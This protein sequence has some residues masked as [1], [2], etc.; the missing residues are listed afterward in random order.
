MNNPTHPNPTEYD[1]HADACDHDAC[2]DVHCR[3]CGRGI[4]DA[5]GFNA[6]G[7]WIGRCEGCEDNRIEAEGYRAQRAQEGR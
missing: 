3:D 4:T 2:S 5:T 1:E 7:K 6:R